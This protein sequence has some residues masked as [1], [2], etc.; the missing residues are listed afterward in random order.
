MRRWALMIPRHAGILHSFRHMNKERRAGLTNCGMLVE[1][2]P[3]ALLETAPTCV[4]CVIYIPPPCRCPKVLIGRLIAGH[5]PYCDVVANFDA[6]EERNEDVVRRCAQRG[7]HNKECD[8]YGFCLEC[9][10][11][12]DDSN[13]QLLLKGTT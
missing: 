1:F 6:I 11:Q 3:V 7:I 4:V 13:V 9:G 10:Y 8:D 5:R 12:F 2:W